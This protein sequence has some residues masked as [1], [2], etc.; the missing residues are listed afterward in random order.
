MCKIC[1][2]LK[3]ERTLH[4]TSYFDD[5]FFS[6]IYNKNF[7]INHNKANRKKN[8]NICS[9]IKQNFNQ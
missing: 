7:E 1:A 9:K 2:I 3:H 6:C 5:I 4:I 8:K